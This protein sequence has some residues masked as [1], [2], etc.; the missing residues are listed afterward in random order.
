MGGSYRGKAVIM[1]AGSSL[2]SLGIPGE[3]EFE[4]ARRVPLRHLRRAALHGPDRRRGG[5][6]AIPQP[7]RRSR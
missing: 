1:A 3:E 2:R 7:T 5:A 4:G 6:E